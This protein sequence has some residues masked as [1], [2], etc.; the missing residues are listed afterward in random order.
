MSIGNLPVESNTGPSSAGRRTGVC[1]VASGDLWA[2]AEVVIATL[3]QEQRNDPTL[4]VSAI[5]LNEG[6][7]AAE[8]RAAGIHTKVFPESRYGFWST[9]REASEFVR[10]RKIDVLHSHRYKENLLA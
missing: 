2:G 4:E 8:L 3:L 7:L 5:L 9:L 6:R 1:H 10:N